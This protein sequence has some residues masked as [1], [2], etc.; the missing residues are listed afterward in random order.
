MAQLPT[1]PEEENRDSRSPHLTDPRTNKPVQYADV[2]EE[3]ER[4][5]RQV[6]RNPEAERAFLLSKVEIVRN[7]PHLNEAEKKRA[8]ADLERALT[9]G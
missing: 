1:T 9:L 7:D 2:R 8:I 3:F 6:P 4:L 5:S